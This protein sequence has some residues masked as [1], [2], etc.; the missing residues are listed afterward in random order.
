[1]TGTWTDMNHKQDE[2]NAEQ[3]TFWTSWSVF[4]FLHILIITLSLSP[5]PCHP[6]S[7]QTIQSAFLSASSVS[8]ASFVTW[9]RLLVVA[10]CCR[11]VHAISHRSRPVHKT[12]VLHRPPPL[13]HKWHWNLTSA[14]KIY[15]GLVELLDFG[16]FSDF[17]ALSSLWDQNCESMLEP[18][19]CAILRHKLR[20]MPST[21]SIFISD[22]K[23]A[24]IDR[25]GMLDGLT[26]Q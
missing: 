6:N 26:V 8:V 5:C 4:R 19:V 16:W 17:V 13:R 12:H 9:Q 14:S 10:S 15:T 1:M 3:K 25:I 7:I 20:R 23:W 18:C 21:S 2:Y 11:S 22:L 24:I